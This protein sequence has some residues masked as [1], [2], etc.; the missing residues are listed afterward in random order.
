[1]GDIPYLKDLSYYFSGRIALAKNRLGSAR[2]AFE[3][4]AKERPSGTQFIQGHIYF[5]QALCFQAETNG[6]SIGRLRKSF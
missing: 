6:S 4:A 2:R 3:K 1:M 5:Y